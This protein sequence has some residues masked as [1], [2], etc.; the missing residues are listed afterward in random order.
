MVG[1]ER[2]C[3][4]RPCGGD[5]TALTCG[6]ADKKRWTAIG[7]FALDMHP[8]AQEGHRSDGD[9]RLRHPGARCAERQVFGADRKGR[10]RRQTPAAQ[11]NPPKARQFDDITGCPTVEEVHLPQE[12][13]DKSCARA[14]IQ[15]PGRAHLDNPSALHHGNLIG[16][17]HRLFLIVRDQNE[18][19]PQALLQLP[20]LE[21]HVF[22]HL[23]VKRAERLVQK[24]HLGLFHQRTRQRDPLAL[25]TRKLVG[26]AV[27]QPFE[28][29]HAQ[30]RLVGFVEAFETGD[31]GVI[32]PPKGYLQRL[33]ELCTEH[34]ILLIFDEVVTGFGRLGTLTAAQYFGV[35]PDMICMAKGMSN[36]S[37][38]MGGV[39]VADHIQRAFMEGPENM[40]ELFHGYTYSGHPLA[41]AAAEASL[42]AYQEEGIFDNSARM[43]GP[44]AKA[45]HALR[46]AP[47]VRDIR[48][49]GLLCGIELESDAHYIGHRGKAVGEACLSEGKLVRNVGDTLI[50]SPPLIIS[51]EQ[52]EDL[53]ATIG[54]AL[55]VC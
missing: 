33:R 53:F 25:P 26:P 36:G 54:R 38:P 35:T 23:P 52:I 49:L 34:D 42:S 3:R 8:V 14:V 32:V 4:C 1:I 51:E 43:A 13:G 2:S 46:D 16:H 30:G 48:T 10:G 44:W 22:A 9:A 19:D 41:V 12:F 39:V 7:P 31:V 27:A 5:C 21:L 29:D 45:A 47:G 17:G 18:G 50:M 15:R 55:A 28:V 40:I 20:Q 24:Q 6:Q 11:R 37:V